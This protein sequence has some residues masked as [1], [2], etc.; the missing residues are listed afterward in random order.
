MEPAAPVRIVVIDDHAVLLESLASSLG[1]RDGIEVVATMHSLAEF[2]ECSGDAAPFDVVV[3]DCDLGDGLGTDI[4]PQAAA[5]GAVVLVLSGWSQALVAA[6]AAQTGCAG[7]VHKGSPLAELERAIRTRV[8][9]RDGLC[10]DAIAALTSVTDQA[11]PEL[12]ERE[13]DILRLLAGGRAAKEIQRDT[14]HVDS[15]GAFA[16]TVD[17]DQARGDLAA[18]DSGQGGA[19]WPDRD[20]RT[21]DPQLIGTSAVTTTPPLGPAS[22]SSEPPRAVAR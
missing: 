11:R 17:P 12:T 5:A 20:S 14:V 18:R 6:A 9:R 15:Y 1:G 3:A 10:G 2:L 7:F 19:T 16:H 4:V 21:S 13:F 22:I 8:R